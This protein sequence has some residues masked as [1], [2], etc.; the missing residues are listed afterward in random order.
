MIAI[1][2]DIHGNYEALKEVLSLIDQMGIK[3]ILC[4]GDVVGYYSQVNECCEELRRREVKC[5]M[6]NHD[7]YIAADSFCPRSQ[8]VNDTLDYQ[9]KIITD[10]NLNWVK[11]FP[12][13]RNV[14]ELRM[15][16]GGWTDPIDE[17]LVNPS[18]DYFE[19]I[20][21]EKFISGHTHVQQL[22]NFKNKIYCNPG[23]VGQPR[24][25]D[26]RAAFATW[27]GLNFELHRVAYDF[28]KVG[29]LMEKA[30]F[31]GYYYERLAVGAKDNG[32]YKG[33]DHS[34][35]N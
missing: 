25:G 16:H 27:D 6:G 32:W 7:W 19:K 31:S 35:K 12:V 21:G 9:R 20:A 1:I 33:S 26:N 23:S 24:D 2:S 28:Q 13:F 4:L 11:K 8:S 10:E 5:L 18:E 34:S 15:V 17:Y 29:E 22:V 30:G 14:G 3:E